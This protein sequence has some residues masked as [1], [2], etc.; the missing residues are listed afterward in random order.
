MTI[1][2]SLINHIQ[3]LSSKKNDPFYIYD[4]NIIKSHCKMFMNI[5]YENK[6]I[7]FAS[8]AND[9]PEFLK[10]IKDEGLSIFVNSLIHLNI[11]KKVG[12][13]GN[14]IVFTSSGM[15][16]GRMRDVKESGAQLNLDSPNQLKLWNSLYPN[17]KV[18]IR[19]NIGDDV[20]PLATRAGYFI[21]K[22]SR[23]GFTV[24][25]IYEQKNNPNIQGLHMYVGT[26]I[27]DINYFMN[28]YQRLTEFAE[29]FPNL[30]YLNFGGG[31]GVDEDGEKTFHM[32]EYKIKV[33]E[34]MTKV[35]TKLNKSIKMILEP[36]R[37]IGGSAGYFICKVTDIKDRG[38]RIYVGVNA[39]SVQFPRPLMYPN[40][41]RHPVMIIRDGEQVIS[42]NLHR[43]FIYG[44]STYSRDFL[45]RD[46][47]CPSFQIG[48]IVAFGNAGSYSSSSFSNFLG[49]T[50]PE[51]V[52]Q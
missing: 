29:L 6:S 20:N 2:K 38:D 15:D 48:D 47:M 21:G 51:E 50:K 11:A 10:I 14:R 12:F 42:K 5:P 37:I 17:V 33:S 44:C 26:D 39:S 3:E 7:H 22:E 46:E 23:L 16:K 9:N 41:A 32:D 30:E 35:S 24:D 1:E 31:F 52:F 27:M 4:K 13:D 45:S 19:C 40:E 36:G 8:M 18:G 34:L 25:E 49:F 43:T 28:C